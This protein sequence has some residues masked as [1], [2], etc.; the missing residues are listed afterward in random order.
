VTPTWVLFFGSGPFALPILGRLAALA[1]GP[2]GDGPL[3]GRIGVRAVV[4]APARP[5]GRRGEPRPTPVAGLAGTLGIPVLT[6]AT[7]RS[8]AVIEELRGLA[9][10]LIVLA[11]YGRLIPQGV[12]DL[13]RHGALNLH[14]SLLPRH[15]G[16]AP[17]AAA[18]LAGDAVT[19]V[20][21]IRMDAGLDS[22]PIVAQRTIELDG[23]EVAPA[24][25]ARLAESAADL[26]VE[27]L[28]GW[29][30]GTLQARAQPGGG[31]T[32]TRPLRRDDGRLDPGRPAAELERQVRA[33][34]PWPGSWTELDGERLIVWSASVLDQPPAGG[35]G[36]EAATGGR[37]WGSR[38][39]TEF[40]VAGDSLALRASPGWLRLDEVQPAGRT[41]MSGAAFRRGLRG[42]RRG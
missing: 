15:R 9:A 8:P 30:S 20:T 39:S 37:L 3:S 10:E 27:A 14:P 1:L 4:T 41:R 19:G 13:P 16:A 42:R 32:L 31:A 7:L 26:L 24:L 18:I 33:Y 6:P 29:L 12:L 35:A 38:S 36:D 21:L 11:D 2:A 28:P 23:R 25:E 22:G 34:Q 17:V 5:S 40:V